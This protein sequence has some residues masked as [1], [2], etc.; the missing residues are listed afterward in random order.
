MIC[1]SLAVSPKQFSYPAILWIQLDRV[2]KMK[3]LLFASSSY[4]ELVRNDG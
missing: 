3:D 4:I 1:D 2:E